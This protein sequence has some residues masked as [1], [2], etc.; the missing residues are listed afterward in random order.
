MPPLGASVPA[1]APMPPVLGATLPPVANEPDMPPDA[2][3]PL[4]SPVSDEQAPII[5]SA[6]TSN[7]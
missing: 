6:P 4:C 2:I 5:A 1:V 3:A 7:Q